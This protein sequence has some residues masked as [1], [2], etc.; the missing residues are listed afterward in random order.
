MSSVPPSNK[1]APIRI[2]SRACAIAFALGA[3]SSTSSAQNTSAKPVSAASAA[4]NSPQA[5][6][7]RVDR[8]SAYYHYMLAHQYEDMANTYGRPE[9]AT[10]AI[11]EYKLA[12]DADPTSKYLTSGLAEL[13]FRTGRVRDAVL[14]AQEQ[15]R[16]DPNNLDAHKL[17][18]SIYLRSLGDGQQQQGGSA[19]EDVLKLAI[20]EYEKI[21]SLEP[22]NVQNRLM[23]GQL[24]SFAHDS[25]RAEEQFSA[26]EKI[27]PGSE[28]TALNL[29]RL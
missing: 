20:G 1:V 4:Q 18:G 3:I 17:L 13:Y 5:N 12:L 10:R 25:V 6:G 21:V 24:Y 2:A 26:A 8:G 15:I 27:D 9:Y 11:E 19:Q 16:K 23:L 14:A 7:E 29:A 28:D 22:N